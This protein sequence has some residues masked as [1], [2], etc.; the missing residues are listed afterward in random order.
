[1][2]L[3]TL[4]WKDRYGFRRRV[5]SLLF[6]CQERKLFFFDDETFYVLM[7]TSTAPG[8]FDLLIYYV[9]LI[10]VGGRLLWKL[11]LHRSAFPM[12]QGQR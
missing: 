3:E 4:A 2:F 7:T 5:F 11:L 9:S 6:F 1:M 12:Q 8:R 10:N